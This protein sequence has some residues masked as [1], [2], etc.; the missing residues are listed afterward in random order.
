MNKY[1]FIKLLKFNN[2]HYPARYQVLGG[3]FP[4]LYLTLSI[5]YYYITATQRPLPPGHHRLVRGVCG[6]DRFI[7]T[8]IG[9]SA[10]N[11][12]V[13]SPRDSPAGHISVL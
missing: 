3:A 10:E 11:L 13:F 6:L 9:A 12:G 2:S 7:R 5:I 8:N 4:Q 1:H